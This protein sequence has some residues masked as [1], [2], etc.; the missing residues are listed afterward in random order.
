MDP[1]DSIFN[2]TGGDVPMRTELSEIRLNLRTKESSRKA[3]VSGMNLEVGQVDRRLLGRRNRFVYLAIAEPWPKCSGIAKVDVESKEV[4][5]FD[6]GKGRFG[7]EPFYVPN[8]SDSDSDS[9]E[10]YLMGFVRDE[11]EEKSE[12]VV[13]DAS[14]MEQVA[15]VMLPARVPYGFHGT[16]VSEYD[17]TRQSPS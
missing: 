8:D 6:Y 16:F 13:V 3:I 11:E 9:D 1:P 14:T 5:R 4:R 2:E 15:A 12:L 7:G 17:L 10:G